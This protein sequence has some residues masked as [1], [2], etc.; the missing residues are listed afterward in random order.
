[1]LALHLCHAIPA[2]SIALNRP[3]PMKLLTLFLGDV[4]L[5]CQLL[6]FGWRIAVCWSRYSC[7]VDSVT[8]RRNF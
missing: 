1:M 5:V 8:V 4:T 6:F 2:A 3:A 7:R